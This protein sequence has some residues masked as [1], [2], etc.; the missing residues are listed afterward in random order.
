MIFIH[1]FLDAIFLEKLN[2]QFHKPSC[3]FNTVISCLSSLNICNFAAGMQTPTRKNMCRKTRW[4]WTSSRPLQ[5]SSSSVLKS[6]LANYFGTIELTGFPRH[7][8]DV[9]TFQRVYFH[10]DG[11]LVILNPQVFFYV[12]TLHRRKTFSAKGTP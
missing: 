5:T 9:Q 7:K 4:V 11:Q 3:T 6:C 12:A 2:S 1:H 8:I 10:T